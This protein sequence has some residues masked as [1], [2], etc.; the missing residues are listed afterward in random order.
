M[1]RY[2][3]EYREKLNEITKPESDHLY[4]SKK[5]K[6]VF[7][8]ILCVLTYASSY[9]LSKYLVELKMASL[10]FLTLSFF[11]IANYINDIFMFYRKCVRM[12]GELALEV[13]KA[14]WIEPLSVLWE[15]K[16]ID[17]KTKKFN[18]M[19]RGQQYNLPLVG[20]Y[21]DP[22]GLE[23]GLFPGVDF[24]ETI[25]P[26]FTI[27]QVEEI[28]HYPFDYIEYL[29][30]AEREIAHM[31]TKPDIMIKLKEIRTTELK[32]RF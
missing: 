12:Q 32:S 4:Y 10:L 1:T 15:V 5:N 13:A 29:S 17:G 11:Q 3:L 6:A 28:I 24:H 27:Y 25:D 14:S 19:L 20:D 30:Q 31:L 21:V 22:K 7:Y 18:V 26:R 9:F 8:F 16:F 23:N 2:N